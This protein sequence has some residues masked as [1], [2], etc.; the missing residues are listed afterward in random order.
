MTEELRERHIDS[1]AAGD[2]V[3]EDDTS[4]ASVIYSGRDH[5]G[6]IISVS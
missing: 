2:N 5:D 6:V 4:S 1:S 3:V